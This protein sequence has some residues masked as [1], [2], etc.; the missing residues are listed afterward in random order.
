[1]HLLSAGRLVAVLALVTVAAC[2]D[3]FA[4]GTA[5]GERAFDELMLGP[6]SNEPWDL[7]R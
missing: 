2:Q 1:M 4:E 3:P 5:P 7:L 6:G